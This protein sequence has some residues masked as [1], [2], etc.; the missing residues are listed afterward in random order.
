MIFIIRYAEKITKLSEHIYQIGV[1]ACALSEDEFNV[2]N[3]GDFW[4]NNMLFKYDDNGKPIQHI[5]VSITVSYKKISIY[6]LLVKYLFF[7]DYLKFY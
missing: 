4:V 3:H 6:F 5:C 1:K 7:L 2:I